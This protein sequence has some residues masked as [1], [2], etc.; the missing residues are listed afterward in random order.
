M[1]NKLRNDIICFFPLSDFFHG[2]HEEALS[3]AFKL[4][5]G[6]VNTVFRGDLSAIDMKIGNET[7]FVQT[8]P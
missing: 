4:G 5:S 8:G 1:E 6:K 7:K 2:F 3:I